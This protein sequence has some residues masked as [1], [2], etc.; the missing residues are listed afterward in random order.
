MDAFPPEKRLGLHVVAAVAVIIGA[1][2]MYVSTALAIS[3]WRAALGG[4]HV[5]T[6]T[7][8]ELRT[9]G[10]SDHYPDPRQRC[11]WDGDFVSDDGKDVRRSVWLAGSLP[12]DTKGG[13]VFRA[14]D[15]GDS[16]YVYRVNDNQTWKQATWS[17][18]GSLFALVAGVLC[19]K[20]W[21]WRRRLRPPVRPR[22]F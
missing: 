10:R 19:F 22:L 8:T 18:A 9:C 4:G 17:G 11:E 20:P 6:V 3:A 7:L 5:G 12:P 16:T 14:R 2:G 15:T 1:V 21:T 13:D